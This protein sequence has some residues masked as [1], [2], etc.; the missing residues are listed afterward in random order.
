MQRVIV[1]CGYGCHLVPELRHYLD[2]V[3][4]FLKENPAPA[5]VIFCGG[6]TQRKSAGESEARIMM[7]YVLPEDMPELGE[8]A[9]FLEDDS[10]L[11]PENIQGAA[12]K[13]EGYVYTGEHVYPGEQI[14]VVIFCEALRALKVGIFARHYMPDY[15]IRIETDSWERMSPI[16]QL[17]GAIYETLG[18]YVP[19]LLAYFR[20]KRI[21]RA[22]QI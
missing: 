2:K 7:N 13:I 4:R 17:M 14:E 18:L 21:R 12:R 15:E 16:K 20:W 22:E 8:A 10:Y 6:F 5:A 11:T 19:G 9:I 1:V 3:V